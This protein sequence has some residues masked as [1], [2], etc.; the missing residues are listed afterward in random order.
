MQ[1][2]IFYINIQN[3]KLMNVNSLQ[4]FNLNSYRQWLLLSVLCT[5]YYTVLQGVQKMGTPKVGNSD[6]HSPQLLKFHR[7]ESFFMNILNS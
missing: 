1:P 4:L 5:I 3:C 7:V 2:D 6:G